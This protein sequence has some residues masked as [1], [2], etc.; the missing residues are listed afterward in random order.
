MKKITLI[1]CMFLVFQLNAQIDYILK[2][3]NPNTHYFEVEMKIQNIATDKIEIKMPV[4]APGSYLVR[5]FSKNVN[6]VR[7]YD[8]SG[9]PLKIYKTR[10][11][12]WMIENGTHK[13]VSVQYEVYAFE[14]SVRTSFL[15]MT[16]GFVSGSGIFMYTESFR[17][18]S[19][20]LTVQPHKTFAQIDTALEP[21]AEGV[22]GDG[23][24]RIFTYSNYDELVDCPIEIGNQK[25]F[26][27]DAAG[28][29]HTVAMY[30]EGNYDV[31]KLKKDMAKIV[32]ASTTIYGEM[33]NKHYTFIIHNVTNAQ[34]GLEHVNSTTLSVS[35]D[36]YSDANYNGFLTLVAHEYFH[37]WNVK[38]LRAKELGPFDYDNEVY[39]PLLYVMEGFTAYYEDLIVHL[40]GYTKTEE[41]L[42]IVQAAAN[43]VAG[44][45]GSKVQSLADASFDAWIKAYKPNENSGNTT[46]TYYS[47][48]GMIASVMDA[49]IIAKYKGE[50]TLNDF[51]RLL[52]AKYY[53]AQNRGFTNDEFEM[54]FSTFMAEDMDW[55]FANHV[56]GTQ[57]PDFKTIFGA[58]GITV[59]DV[60]KAELSAGIV[61]GGNGVLRF[62]RS[63]S[64]AEK[65]GLSPYDF[66]TTIDGNTVSA[67]QAG[68]ILGAVKKGESVKVSFL[69]DGVLLETIF[70]GEEYTKQTFKFSLPKDAM[71]NPM[72]KA[73]FRNSK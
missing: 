52:Y 28:C 55:F 9:T 6:Q 53:K 23:T 71:K 8:E 46:I 18:Q 19:G 65:A 29:K 41:Y 21:L 30:G 51:M 64:A 35:R 36:T 14:L 26:E 17:N 43:Y 25:V 61:E 24:A 70:T 40:A 62:V 22:S 73:F 5:D 69:R 7:A 37:L 67:G 66:I 48:G 56:R 47:G 27:F 10:K 16:H 54:E 38:R 2:M 58:I 11:N 68:R 1:I 13:N 49:L 34:G 12:A 57:L 31:K 50:K 44:N 42:G 15:D 72:T 39:T 59:E 45:P 4:W 3:S 60:S 33:P 32:E 20:K 63:G